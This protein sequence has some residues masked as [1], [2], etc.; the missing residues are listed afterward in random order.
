MLFLIIQEVPL[1]MLKNK[2][3]L[4]LTSPTLKMSGF[5][6]HSMK[7]WKKLDFDVDG[8]INCNG[9]LEV[10]TDADEDDFYDFYDGDSCRCINCGLK[11]EVLLGASE[12]PY[13]NWKEGLPEERTDYFDQ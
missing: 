11:G 4:S 5:H 7:N 13:I 3:N 6:A 2:I 9:N 1:K 10:F 8:C 12:F